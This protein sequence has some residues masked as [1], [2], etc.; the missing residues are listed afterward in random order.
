MN[1]NQKILI[2]IIIILLMLISL[3]TIY[4]VFLDKNS[5]NIDYINSENGADVNKNNVLRSNLIIHNHSNLSLAMIDSAKNGTPVIQFGNGEE[6]VTFIVAGVH[7]NQLPPQIAAI[8]LIDY[9]DNKKIHGTVYVVP[10]AAP[11]LTANNE[12]LLNGQNLN[13]VADEVGTPS[14]DIVTYAA[15]RNSSFVGDFHSTAP[16]AVPGHD[17]IMCSKYPT[18]DSYL[19][20]IQMTKFLNEGIEVHEVAGVDYEGAIEDVL[21]MKGTPSITGLSTSPHGDIS[22][23]SVETSF[24]QMLAL[25]KSNGNI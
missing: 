8:Q 15:S 4:F 10:F 23:G 13:T 20:A 24:N 1:N 7:G 21:N 2:S 16:G 5:V 22:S 17:T 25:L 11:N 9:L 3:T 14:N 18:Y 19:F 6:P 12:K